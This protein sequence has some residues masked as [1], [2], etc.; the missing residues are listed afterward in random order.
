ME[1]YQILVFVCIAL[2]I[3]CGLTAYKIMRKAY[4]DAKNDPTDWRQVLV[5][6]I[7]T[8]TPNGKLPKH[9]RFL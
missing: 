6:N 1:K 5:K 9:Q 7:K 2:I 3:I 8:P 4:R